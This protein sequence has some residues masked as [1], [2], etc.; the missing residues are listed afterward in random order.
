M[1]IHHFGSKEALLNEILTLIEGNFLA[2]LEAH[3]TDSDPVRSLERF[4]KSLTNGQVD[5]VERLAF[6]VWGRALVQ[7][8]GFESFLSSLT[9]PWTAQIETS[10]KSYG[11]PKAKRETLAA[12]IVST[13]YGLLLMRLTARQD[14]T[15]EAAFKQF[16]RWLR[17]ELEATRRSA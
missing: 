11:L 6:E 8:E 3:S 13:F 17:A 2:L 10:L 16:S 12:L 1:L 5:H 15:V 9:E 14:H 4:W 7:P